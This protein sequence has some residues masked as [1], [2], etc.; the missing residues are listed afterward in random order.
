VLPRADV[1]VCVYVGVAD[2]WEIRPSECGQI[3]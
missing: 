2:Y 1:C 3:S